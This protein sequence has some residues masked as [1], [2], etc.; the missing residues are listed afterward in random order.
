MWLLFTC[1]QSVFYSDFTFVVRYERTRI[2]RRRVP[3]RTFW[4]LFCCRHRTHNHRPPH[5]SN[6]LTIWK[7]PQWIS[8]GPCIFKRWRW[9]SF[10]DA[11]GE[12]PGSV[13]S[14]RR[15]SAHAWRF[16]HP[17]SSYLSLWFVA[18]VPKCFCF[19]ECKNG[20]D[21]GTDLY[22]STWCNLHLCP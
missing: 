21:V 17:V 1:T 14:P 15:A 20:Y 5:H 10:H 4:S 8:H 2:H 6:H 9:Y 12:R 22:V 13:G 18:Y 16:V 3:V 11:F 7:R 19:S